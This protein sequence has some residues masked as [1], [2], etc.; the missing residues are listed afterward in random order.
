MNKKEYRTFKA[1]LLTL[2]LAS[3]FTL[4]ALAIMKLS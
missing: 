1:V 3:L 2:G 4:Y